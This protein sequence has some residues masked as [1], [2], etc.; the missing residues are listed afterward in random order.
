MKD[1]LIIAHFTQVPGESGNGR[2]HYIAQ[3]LNNENIS[4]EIVTQLF[5]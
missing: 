3:N 5:S 2:F 1:L 4:V